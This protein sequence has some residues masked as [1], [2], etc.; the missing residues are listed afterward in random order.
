[1]WKFEGEENIQLFRMV[2]LVLGNLF[3][4]TLSR[5]CLQ[6]TVDLRSNKEDYPEAYKAVEEDGYVENN[7][8]TAPTK[9]EIW[10]K[11]NELEFVL[12]H[13]GFH[14]KPFI[15]SSEDTPDIKIGAVICKTVGANTKEEKA[16]GTYWNVKED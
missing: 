14:H 12:K 6:E 8:L 2:W 7:F 3:S 1:M 5:V 13:G 9:E 15:V 11:I 4:L 10:R 16:L